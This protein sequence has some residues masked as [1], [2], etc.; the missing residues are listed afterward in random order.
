MAC[1][2]IPSDRITGMDSSRRLS[3][4]LNTPINVASTRLRGVVI[5]AR[6]CEPPALGQAIDSVDGTICRPWVIPQ[7][8]HGPRRVGDDMQIAG[9]QQAGEERPSSGRR[10]RSQ[11][12]HLRL[13]PPLRRRCASFLSRLH[14]D[15]PAKHVNK[16]ACRGS[17]PVILRAVAG[18]VRRVSDPEWSR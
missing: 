14:G 18:E 4:R 8:D 16:Q 6:G 1:V 5:F 10:R 17:R 9:L 13:I 15:R 3:R 7:K 11:S 2:P 12:G